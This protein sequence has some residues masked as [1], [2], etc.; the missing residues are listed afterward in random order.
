M[1]FP[2]PK[3]PSAIPQIQVELINTTGSYNVNT[4]LYEETQGTNTLFYGALLPL[5]EKELEYSD[6]TYNKDTRKLYTE[7]ILQINDTIEVQGNVYTVDKE[8]D[9]S[10]LPQTTFRRYFVKRM[11]VN[12]R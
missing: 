2:I 5:N 8:T 4:G 10:G 7:K 9:Y 6:G 11:G 1:S 3:M 12:N